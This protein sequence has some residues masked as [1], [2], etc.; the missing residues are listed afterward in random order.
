ML[1]NIRIMPHQIP[2][3]MVDLIKSDYEHQKKFWDKLVSL[4]LGSLQLGNI[5]A[6]QCINFIKNHKKNADKFNL[7]DEA[8]FRQ[9]EV[10]DTVFLVVFI[11]NDS[12]EFNDDVL[13]TKI[14]VCDEKNKYYTLINLNG[15][16]QAINDNKMIS[17]LKLYFGMYSDIYPVDRTE[18]STESLN[19]LT[20]LIAYIETMYCRLIADEAYFSYDA[21]DPTFKA[22]LDSRYANY[23]PLIKEVYSV[24]NEGLLYPLY[25]NAAKLSDIGYAI[26]QPF[27]DCYALDNIMNDVFN[28]D[29]NIEWRKEIR[30]IMKNDELSDKDKFEKIFLKAP[31]TE[32][33]IEILYKTYDAKQ[34]M[35]EISKELAN[36]EALIEEFPEEKDPT[37]EEV[38]AKY[39]KVKEQYEKDMSIPATKVDADKTN[40]E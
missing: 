31:V 20:A 40:N 5:V 12:I 22:L 39:N 19:S 16:I 14:R 9:V 38:K 24:Y 30:E 26:S 35:K 28:R 33:I 6:D 25:Y 18:G 17:V 34:V 8:K 13:I 29:V 4:P 36:I 2:E 7:Y 27:Y 37:V 32:K 10:Y 15:V 1:P 23:K 3:T 11:D 21:N